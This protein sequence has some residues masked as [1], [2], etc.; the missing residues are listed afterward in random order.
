MTDIYV[1]N[2]PECEG[3]LLR[4]LPRISEKRQ[5]LYRKSRAQKSRA[6]IIGSEVLLAHALSLP[7]P[8][9]YQTSQNGKPFISGRRHFNI[10]HSGDFVVCAVSDCEIGID[11]E[12]ICRM[13]PRLSHK[14]LTPL[15][16]KQSQEF[17]GDKLSHFL[18][19]KWVRK[20][21]Y[22][23]LSGEGLRRS[24]ACFEFEGDRLVGNRNIFSRCFS[25]SN[26]QLLAVCS[27]E[28]LKITFHTVSK[29]D[30]LNLR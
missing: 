9:Q 20:E 11:T 8:C 26:E 7:L 22:L 10:S 24:P 19:E 28:P 5:E 27:N 29:D 18:C 30:L 14:F 17:T 2:I 13:T 1:L 12:L 25:L 6:F 3:Q 23:K 15:E 21:S 16:I 4:L